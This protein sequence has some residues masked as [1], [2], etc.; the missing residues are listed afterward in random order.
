MVISVK[1]HENLNLT[2]LHEKV[3]AEI[4]DPEK[5]TSV[6]ERAK[7]F[8]MVYEYLKPKE[9]KQPIVF[10]KKH[11]EAKPL[12]SVDRKRINQRITIAWRYLRIVG[13]YVKLDIV[14]VKSAAEDAC[15]ECGGITEQVDDAIVCTECGVGEYDVEC[16]PSH[17]GGGGSSSAWKKSET[18]DNTMLNAILLFQGK[19]K[20]LPPR[21]CFDKIRA[22]CEK[23][24]I[25]LDKLSLFA[26]QNIMQT[27]ELKDYYTFRN[28]IF[29]ELT[30]K[31]CP[32]ISQHE[33]AI[34]ERCNTL[35][36]E[37][38]HLIRSNKKSDPRVSI[39]LR[40]LL[41]MEGVH[42][43]ACWF[44]EIKTP[45]VRESFNLTMKNACNH[46]QSLH[47]DQNWTFVPI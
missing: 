16:T 44:P 37:A 7:E 47:P 14:H 36:D 38:G 26:L 6:S 30:G 3:L 18:K 21:E 4:S 39:I 5:R 11:S 32:D 15:P 29:S 20:K 24:S 28:Y 1:F 45:S 9:V 41:E 33:S 40:L 34:L 25:R 22:H 2:S 27:L 19:Q 23:K 43:D 46:V 12:S 35:F 31:P 17:R 10:G 8:L 13:K 42:I